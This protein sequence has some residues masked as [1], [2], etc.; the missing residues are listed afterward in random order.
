M[1]KNL[2]IP[3]YEDYTSDISYLLLRPGAKYK[4]LHSVRL[5]KKIFKS[6]STISFHHDDKSDIKKEIM[7][8]N[9]SKALE[10]LDIPAKIINNKPDTFLENLY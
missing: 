2:G 5:I 4:K 1:V 8:L 6:P 9:N 3:Q 7:N 10:N